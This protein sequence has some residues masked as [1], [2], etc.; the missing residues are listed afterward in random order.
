MASDTFGVE[1]WEQRVHSRDSRSP[2][3]I[4]V[5]LERD[6]MTLFW[7]HRNGPQFWLNCAWMLPS[8]GSTATRFVS[9]LPGPHCQPASKVAMPVRWRVGSNSGREISRSASQLSL[10][11]AR[12]NA[13]GSWWSKPCPPNLTSSMPAPCGKRSWPLS[14][15][16]PRSRRP[17]K[18]AAPQSRPAG[19]S[20]FAPATG[21]SAT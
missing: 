20:S 14:A 21:S 5:Q 2:H 15:A 9:S 13:T 17:T 16:G 10:G 8:P 6:L 18:K 7:P 12:L 11:R 3:E 4:K 1:M 19:G